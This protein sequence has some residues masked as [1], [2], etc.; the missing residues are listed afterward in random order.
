MNIDKTWKFAP[1][2]EAIVDFTQRKL[3]K[4]SELQENKTFQW[5][6]GILTVL[7]KKRGKKGLKTLL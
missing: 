5:K 7:S 3:Q 6:F 2:K 1:R 4:Y